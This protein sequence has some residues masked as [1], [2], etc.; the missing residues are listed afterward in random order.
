MI[1]FLIEIIYPPNFGQ[2]THLQYNLSHV[3]KFNFVYD[4]M[5]KD[6]DFITFVSKYLYFKKA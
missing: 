5:G 6:N 3:I 4:V 2:I 1:T